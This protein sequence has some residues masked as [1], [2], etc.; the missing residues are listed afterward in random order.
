AQLATALAVGARET[1]AED[2][3]AHV[4]LV[5]AF[6]QGAAAAFVAPALAR[7]VG[8][9][10]E[11]DPLAVDAIDVVAAE[12]M[13]RAAAVGVGLGEDDPI[14]GDAVDGADMLLVVTDHFHMLADLAEQAAFLHAL[15][16]PAAKL[17]FEP[18]LIL[19]MIVV[20]VAVELVELALPPRV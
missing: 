12:R 3:V 2:A 19:A 18:R 9:A 15:F 20:I 7:L 13:V 5:L 4:A 10:I 16:A 6:E 17:A 11:H 1:P 14:T 8:R